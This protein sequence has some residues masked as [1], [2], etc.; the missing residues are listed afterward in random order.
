ISNCHDIGYPVLVNGQDYADDLAHALS[1]INVLLVQVE[2]LEKY[3]ESK[4]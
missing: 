4:D 2:K 3:I 1:V